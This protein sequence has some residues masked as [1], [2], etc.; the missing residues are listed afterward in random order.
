VIGHHSFASSTPSDHFQLKPVRTNNR[1]KNCGK[2]NHFFIQKVL[3]SKVLM[4]HNHYQILLTAGPRR[5]P[6]NWQNPK[7]KQKQKQFQIAVIE[8]NDRR[9][10]YVAKFV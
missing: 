4:N 6:Q 5:R 3:A 2:L 8:I 7:S 10:F 9:Y 1:G